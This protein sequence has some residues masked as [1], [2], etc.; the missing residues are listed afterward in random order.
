MA[1]RESCCF[2]KRTRMG[3]VILANGLSAD[4]K[5]A[6][7]QA[8]PTAPCQRRIPRSAVRIGSGCAGNGAA[9]MHRPPRAPSREAEKQRPP[10]AVTLLYIAVSCLHAILTSSSIHAALAHLVDLCNVQSY[11]VDSS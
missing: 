4:C 1:R 8:K 7:L 6:S 11:V 5:T 10:L 2:C 9:I 3:Q